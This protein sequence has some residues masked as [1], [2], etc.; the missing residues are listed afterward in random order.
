MKRPIADAEL[1]PGRNMSFDQLVRRIRT[2]RGLDRE[3]PEFD[4]KNG[5]ECAKFLFLLEA[6]GPRAVETGFIS[7][8]NPDPTARNFQVQLT[9]AAI[10]RTEIALWN[11]V[12]WYLEQGQRIRPAGNHDFREALPYLPPLLA[13]MKNLCC[14]VLVGAAARR[15]HFLLSRTT[16]ARILACHHPSAR[17]MHANP[18]ASQENIEIFRYMK[19]SSV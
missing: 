3:V 5:N 11:V 12:P 6:P 14:V 17:A 9:S 13:P 18:Q 10:D 7:F 15:A 4:P 1:L 16:T 19:S 2:D 8:D